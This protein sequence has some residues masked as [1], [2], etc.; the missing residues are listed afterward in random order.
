[1][2][3]W[4]RWPPAHHCNLLRSLAGAP[5][6]HQPIAGGT[7]SEPRRLRPEARNAIRRA[8][9]SHVRR[10]PQT[11]AIRRAPPR[12]APKTNT[13][14]RQGEQR[15]DRSLPLGPDRRTA[16]WA[17]CLSAAA[18]EFST[19]GSAGGLALRSA[20]VR[21]TCVPSARKAAVTRKRHEAESTE[22][23][24]ASAVDRTAE[25]SEDV[26]ES[27]E[28]GQ[29]A[30][31]E[32]VRRFVDTVDEKLPSLGG[33][34]PSRRQEIIDAALE[35]ADRLVHTQHDFLRKTVDSAGKALSRADDGK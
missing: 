34:H 12:Q 26:L 31:I 27:L 33:E 1:L 19:D 14:K 23:E 21:G 15:P 28:S 8:P 22:H 16:T 6:V 10:F 3:W 4:V 17:R 24:Q 20:S 2:F 29:R 11:A 9:R 7:I 5:R 13:V 18:S 32:A 30:A 25:F 35:M